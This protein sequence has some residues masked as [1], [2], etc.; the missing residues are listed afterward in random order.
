[1]S[2]QAQIA[3]TPWVPAP[4]LQV[5]DYEMDLLKFGF[6]GWMNAMTIASSFWLTQAAEIGTEL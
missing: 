5:G 1:M 4:I 3:G 6:F 2:D